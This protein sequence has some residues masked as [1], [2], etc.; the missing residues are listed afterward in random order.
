MTTEHASPLERAVAAEERVAELEA[1]LAQLEASKTACPYWRD[2]ALRLRLRRHELEARVKELEDGIGQHR[3]VQ[4][5]VFDVPRPPLLRAAIPGRPGSLVP[6]RGSEGRRRVTIK[7]PFVLYL[8]TRHDSFEYEYSKRFAERRHRRQA[9]LGWPVGP[10][11]VV[12]LPKPQANARL[13]KRE[14][15]RG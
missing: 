4:P 5:R 6:P 3:D 10:I 9:D 12:K 15:T 13:A 1:K 11:V 14:A 7:K 8:W 2:E